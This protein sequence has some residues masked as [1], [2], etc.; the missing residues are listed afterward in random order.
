MMGA[1]AHWRPQ[2]VVPQPVLVPIKEVYRLQRLR[3]Q[4]DNATSGGTK[5]IFKVISKNGVPLPDADSEDAPGDPDYGINGM[6]GSRR[7]SNTFGLQQVPSHAQRK[8][9][10]AS[11]R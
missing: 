4:L 3:E 1:L 5:N 10:V 11:A 9:S 8:A 2:P 6:G 7:S